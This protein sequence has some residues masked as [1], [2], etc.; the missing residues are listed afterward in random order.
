MKRHTFHTVSSVLVLVIASGAFGQDASPKP[1][2]Q[3]GQPTSPTTPAAEADEVAEQAS[4]MR[5]LLAQPPEKLNEL[6]RQRAFKALAALGPGRRLAKWS[7]R[8]ENIQTKRLD[9][10]SKAGQAK[11]E[12][13][14]L[15]AE[16]ESEMDE[17]GQQ[18]ADDENECN[19]QQMFVI[20]AYRPRLAEL[21]DKADY[22]TAEAAETDKQLASVRCHVVELER[23][24]RLAERGLP[25]LSLPSPA[26][27]DDNE[28]VAKLLK[29]I[30]VD[31]DLSELE[32]KLDENL[33]ETMPFDKPADLATTAPKNQNVQQAMAELENLFK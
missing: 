33:D 13:D 28:A 32:I 30:E 18:F 2:D 29:E 12:R 27:I 9:W 15:R 21:K 10:L 19:R 4:E 11:K 17:I 31:F 25:F 26:T 14:E 1:A 6:A 3:V 8:Q 22:W 24:V 5:E 16:L 7:A 20:N 23:D